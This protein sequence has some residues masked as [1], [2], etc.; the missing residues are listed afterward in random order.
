MPQATGA[1]A[2]II[3]DVESTYGSTPGAPASIVLPFVSENLTQ[4]R[5]LFRTNVM[6]GN[7]NQVVPKRGNKDVG[8]SIT[9]EL[10]PYMGK[11]LKHLL[12]ANVTTG[13]GPYTHTMKIGA[14]PVSLCF[15]KQ[16]LDLGTPQYALF[17]GCRIGR[18]S[19]SFGNEG[20]IPLTLDII[21][22]KETL[23]GSSFHGSP[24]D[25]GHNPFDMF[26]ATIL[27]GG[28]SIAIVSSVSLD[29]SNDLDGGM[30]VI[31]GA[32]ERR[33]LPEGVT[34]ITGT[35]TA[36]FED[37]TLYTK[38]VNNTESSLKITLSRGNGLG[39]AGNESL[40]ILVPEL[41]YEQNSPQI[42]GPRGIVVELPFSAYYDNAAETTSLQM[43]LK[44]T[45]ATL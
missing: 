6:R 21:G 28:S 23:S 25:L 4:K 13:A 44:N 16:Y 12:G 19:F 35:L 22:K 31:G 30:Y 11:P 18:G 32:G 5:A 38:A 10:N 20:V 40:E 24:T 42:A 26:E 7:R 29:I 39:S 37:A 45:Q 34:A 14:L 8:G 43:I 15:E 17:N 1:N 2:K 33:A 41:V 36:L 9:T 27:E 3:Y